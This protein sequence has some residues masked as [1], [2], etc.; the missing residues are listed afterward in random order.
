MTAPMRVTL[1]GKIGSVTHWLEDCA[2]GLLAAGHTIQLCPT[3]DPR[4][5]AAIERLLLARRLGAPRA[6][7][8]ARAVG[9]FRPDLVV[10]VRGYDVPL[11][12][13]DRL[14]ALPGRP[15][16]V[17]W[18]GDGFLETD[19][20]IASRYDLVAHTDS[21]FVEQHRS[22]R[23]PVPCL[24]LPHAA[25]MRL[26]KPI[27]AARIPRVV[28]VANPTPHRV[29][30]LN[31]ISTPIE[32]Y[33][34]GWR[35]FPAVA[36]AIHPVRLDI[37]A[38]AAA[39]RSHLAVLNIR[40]EENVVYGLN[41]RSFDP[42]FVGTPVVSDDQRDLSTCFEEGAEVLVYRCAAELDDICSRL[43]RDPG[44]AASIGAAG[45]RRVL[46][47]HGYGNRLMSVVAALP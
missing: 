11:Q 7:W 38:L 21:F 4:L 40:N 37:P 20:A 26:G 16:M 23:F 28:L 41:Q 24:Y 1:I 25:N 14:R 2:A 35:P 32:L 36:H 47:E 8:T 44:L 42:Y 3:R 45:R 5:N 34:P 43:Q 18:V 19:R 46:A 17:A 12:I 9:R 30:L 10:A 27:P 6:A 13:L 22:Q 33:G 29:A 31:R 39:Y 15:P